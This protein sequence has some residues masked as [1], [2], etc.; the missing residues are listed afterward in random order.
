MCQH[1]RLTLASWVLKRCKS[2]RYQHQTNENNKYNVSHSSCTINDSNLEW[3]VLFDASMRSSKHTC[4]P[5]E[6][7]CSTMY[8]RSLIRQNAISND[9]IGDPRGLSVNSDARIQVLEA[10][11]LGV[12]TLFWVLAK[13]RRVVWPAEDGK[14]NEA[15]HL[16]TH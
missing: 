7:R 6:R 8:P 15:G 1:R 2:D 11:L 3:S 5:G 12:T 13:R 10:I 16:V 4:I 9:H 14:L